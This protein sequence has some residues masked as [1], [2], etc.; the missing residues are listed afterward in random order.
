M[1]KLWDEWDMPNS[2]IGQAPIQIR[3]SQ[4]DDVM[5]PKMLASSDEKFKLPGWSVVLVIGCA[6]LVFL[7]I[8]L[9]VLEYCRKDKADDDVEAAK[10]MG[11]VFS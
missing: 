10:L 9:V 3:A 11:N 2:Y 7:C 8:I 5:G 6:V 1:I 4:I